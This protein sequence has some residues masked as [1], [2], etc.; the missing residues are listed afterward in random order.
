VRRLNSNFPFFPIVG[1]TFACASGLSI[2][3]RHL[4]AGKGT[5]SQFRQRIRD[6]LRILSSLPA[7]G[8][9][10]KSIKELVTTMLLQYSMC[11]AIGKRSRLPVNAEHTDE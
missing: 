11:S 5:L 6:S 2:S 10:A 4:C 9:M 1:H 8:W 7:V 3:V